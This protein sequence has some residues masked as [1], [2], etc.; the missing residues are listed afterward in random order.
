M[1]N[2]IIYPNG[3][4]VA[5]VT[6]SGTLPLSE[7]ARKDVPA[8]VPY[9]IVDEADLPSDYSEFDRWTADFSNPDG[10][11]IGAVTWFAERAAKEVEE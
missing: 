10:Y 9:R 8:G 11:G 6:P 4:G 1:T 2:L 3:S 7:V 5:V